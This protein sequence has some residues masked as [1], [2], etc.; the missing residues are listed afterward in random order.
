MRLAKSYSG[1]VLLSCLFLDVEWEM[2]ELLLSGFLKRTSS[3]QF[4]TMKINWE[5][6]P[7]DAKFSFLS[8]H[9]RVN[10]VLFLDLIMKLNLKVVSNNLQRYWIRIGWALQQKSYNSNSTQVITVDGDCSRIQIASFKRKKTLLWPQN[11][12]HS[13]LKKSF[14]SGTS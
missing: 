5:C 13:K 12:F 6:K 7:I 2:C 11:F 14:S 9:C 1:L 8:F 10:Q 4:L 3:R